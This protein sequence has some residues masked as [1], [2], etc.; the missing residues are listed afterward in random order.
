MGRGANSRAAMPARVVKRP[1][2]AVAVT[3]DQ[4]RIFA[5]LQGQI[6]ACLRDLAVVSDK[7]PIAIPERLQLE[8]VV[9]R[10]GVEVPGKWRGRVVLAQAG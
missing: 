5:D 10:A 2:I 4:N 7:H 1:D 3:H 9:A 8:L 6:V